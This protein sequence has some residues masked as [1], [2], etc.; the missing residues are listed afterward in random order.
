MHKL[1]TLLEVEEEEQ[2]GNVE[3][4]LQEKEERSHE[5]E[6]LQEEG[7]RPEDCSAEGVEKEWK[8]ETLALLNLGLPR[9]R[10]RGR[11][12]CQVK[13]GGNAHIKMNFFAKSKGFCN[14]VQ[15]LLLLAIIIGYIL[16]VVLL[17][18][19]KFPSRYW[20]DN[21]GITK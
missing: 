10:R 2:E 1:Q 9:Q 12:Q 15:L 20:E 7:P 5:E 11:R 16:L 6:G 13:K 14:C 4:G 19:R 8:K 18:D 3:E 21:L 17:V